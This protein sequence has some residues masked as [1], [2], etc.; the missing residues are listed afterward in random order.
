M[1]GK[2][3]YPT[4]LSSSAWRDESFALYPAKVASTLAASFAV[5]ASVFG[6]VL[7]PTIKNI[8]TIAVKT[9]IPVD[10]IIWNLLLKCLSMQRRAA[11]AAGYL[12]HPRHAANWTLV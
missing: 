10:L 9:I 12:T 2:M 1:S 4:D 7:H 11:R 3:A 8:P 6:A 5:S